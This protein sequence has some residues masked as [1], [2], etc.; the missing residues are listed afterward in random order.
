MRRYEG[1]L[2]GG[3]QSG[4]G[5][6]VSVVEREALLRIAA[7]RRTTLAGVVRAAVRDLIAEDA[8]Q[9]ERRVESA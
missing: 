3:M 8:A 2:K 9:G 5:F 1:H 6:R 7:E 4:I